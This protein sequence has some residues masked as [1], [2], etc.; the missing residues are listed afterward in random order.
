MIMVN[1]N[2]DASAIFSAKGYMGRCRL[3][4]GIAIE[5]QKITNIFESIVFFCT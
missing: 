5:F 4:S 1:N 2:D 3:F